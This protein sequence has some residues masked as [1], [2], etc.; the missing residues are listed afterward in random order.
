MEL[1]IVWIVDKYGI[2]LSVSAKYAN[3]Y[4]LLPLIVHRYIYIEMS[5]I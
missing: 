5:L 4:P 2:N 1:S 3:M